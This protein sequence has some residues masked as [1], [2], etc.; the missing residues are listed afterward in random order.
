VFLAEAK[1]QANWECLA[2]L[3]AALPESDARAAFESA[4][5][6]VASQED[7]HFLWARETRSRLIR[8]QAQSPL[9][10]D[11]TSPI[12]E[13]IALVESLIEQH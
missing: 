8:A 10:V 2:R 1:D 12:E 5:E 6:Q 13:Q 9:V 4:A 3:A 11:A 7:E